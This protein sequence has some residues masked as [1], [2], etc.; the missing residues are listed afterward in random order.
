M[1][2]RG[3]KFKILESGGGDGGIK[4]VGPHFFKTGELDDNLFNKYLLKI[5]PRRRRSQVGG[6]GGRDGW[7]DEGALS[8]FLVNKK[9]NTKRIT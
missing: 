7:I 3:N 4:N 9:K 8:A 5:R 1:L 6:G 2:R